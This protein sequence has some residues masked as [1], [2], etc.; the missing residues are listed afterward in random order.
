MKYFELHISVKVVQNNLL[1]ERTS[2]FRIRKKA[3]LKYI[4]ECFSLL[5]KK[6]FRSQSRMQSKK[7]MPPVI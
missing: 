7:I 1:G 2:E 6:V 4:M 3:G 5:N